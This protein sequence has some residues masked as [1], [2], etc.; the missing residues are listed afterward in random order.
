[1][2]ARA[3]GVLLTGMGADGAKGLLRMKERGAFTIGQDQQSSVVYGMP[4]EAMKLGAV[5]RQ[6]SLQMIP[7]VLLNRLKRASRL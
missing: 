3:V 7:S 6:A 5:T 2:G 1:M 4:M